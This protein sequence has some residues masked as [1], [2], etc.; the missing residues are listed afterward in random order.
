[1]KILFEIDN[2]AR[3]S[4]RVPSNRKRC[5]TEENRSRRG[6]PKKLRF[7]ALFYFVYMLYQET[8]LPE[9]HRFEFLKL[10]E[11]ILSLPKYYRL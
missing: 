5:P 2:W 9:R 1:M 3:R 4:H 8:R 10:R 6:S 11:A 7:Q